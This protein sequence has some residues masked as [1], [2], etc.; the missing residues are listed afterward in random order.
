VNMVMNGLQISPKFF[1]QFAKY[2]R[3]KVYP[4]LLRHL[5]TNQF[6][7]KCFIPRFKVIGV[8]VSRCCVR[9][10]NMRAARGI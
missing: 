6:Q 4:T 7:V 9:R 1:H 3:F 10:G 5:L 8:I 2:Q